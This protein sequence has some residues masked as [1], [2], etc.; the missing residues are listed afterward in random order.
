MRQSLQTEDHVGCQHDWISIV[1]VVIDNKGNEEDAA[2]GVVAAALLDNAADQMCQVSG[3]EDWWCDLCNLWG[4]DNVKCTENHERDIWL[5]FYWYTKEQY[6][7][8]F[9]SFDDSSSNF[10]YLDKT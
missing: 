4:G 8:Y 3:D 10:L 7:C 5:L 6:Y 9:K 1:F 2:A